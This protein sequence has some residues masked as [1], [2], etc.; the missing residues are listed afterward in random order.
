ML[1]RVR[2]LGTFTA[3]RYRD[4]REL[5][6]AT[7]WADSARWALLVVLG[8]QTYTL[9]GS[10][11]WVGITVFANMVPLFLFA[12]LGGFLADRFDR[13]KLAASSMGV[14]VGLT[15]ALFGL[16]AF[17]YI[18]AWHVATV[19]FGVG[20]SQ[21]VF[22]PTVSA[23]LPNL[24][25]RDVLLNAV[26]LRAV[27][28]RGTRIIGPG[29]SGPLLATLGPVGGLGLVAA[30]YATA[31]LQL[32]RIHASG[33]E[34]AERATSGSFLGDF[35]LGFTYVYRH[36]TVAAVI[37]LTALHC[38]LTMAF[39][40]M[41]PAFST[42]ALKAGGAVFS[43]LVVSL[44]VGAVLGSLAIASVSDER[45][46]GQLFLFTGLFSGLTLA[47]LA[48]AP[49]FPLALLLIAGV[50]ASQGAFMALSQAFVQGIIPD[51]VRGR[52]SS[53]YAMHTGGVMA[54][55]NL[56]YGYTA[57]IWGAPSIFLMTGLIFVGLMVVL[58]M[59]WPVLR[60]VYRTGAGVATPREAGAPLAGLES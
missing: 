44:G 54:F 58:S 15:L 48:F 43:Y 60:R 52:I 30:L 33:R 26:A 7:I 16:T 23:L 34:T 8:W 32:L 5:W 36:Q 1:S 4:Y 28:L 51:H 24:V 53:V 57:D 50:G 18:Q 56:A 41:L 47:A 29:L 6:W 22:M 38:G 27:S 17:G 3:L 42:V 2:G 49:S 14:N 35:V 13:R 46:K 21:A 25:P 55:L 37:I 10:S 9:S 19:A 20:M 45:R 39:D 59:S 11:L 12:P 31:A 40:S